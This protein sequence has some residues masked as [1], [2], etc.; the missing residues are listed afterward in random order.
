LSGVGARWEYPYTNVPRNTWTQL[1]P[2]PTVQ[3]TD[4]ILPSAPKSTISADIRY[5]LTPTYD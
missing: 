4:G 3:I 2:Y 1:L 5:R